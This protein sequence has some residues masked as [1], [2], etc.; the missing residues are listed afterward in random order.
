M[1]CGKSV[2]KLFEGDQRCE[3]IVKHIMD[4]LYKEAAGMPMPTIL[5]MLELAK[6]QIMEEI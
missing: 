1:E 6:I 5:G 2:V 4:L 3:A